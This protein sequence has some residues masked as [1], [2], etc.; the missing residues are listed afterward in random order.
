MKEKLY[1]L[2]PNVLIFF[3]ILSL[4]YSGLTFEK[5]IRLE[6][7]IFSTFLKNLTEIDFFFAFFEALK[8]IFQEIIIPLLPFLLLTMLGFSLAFL[9]RDIEF[10]VFMLFQA[11]FFAVLLF[12]N[13]SLITIFIYLGIIAASLSLKNFEK[14]EINFSSGSSLIQSCMKWL[15][16]FLSIGFFLSLQLN[17]QNYYKTIH[18]A[19]MDFIKM[20]VPDINSFIRAQTSQASQFINETTEGI[21]NALSDAYS[22]L[23]VQQREACGIMYTALV[24]AIDEYKTEAN[25]KV[26]Q[27]IEDADKK[28]E[29]YVEQI[30]PFDQIVKITPLILS[31]LL[32]T[33]LEI[34]KPLLALLFGILFSLAGKIKSK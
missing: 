6:S 20:F 30:V 7:E 23:D 9:T 2:I 14:R 33:L 22:K 3:G 29:E 8:A 32:F 5:A 28:V 10:P 18:Q 16:V 11:I 21:K 17:L 31:I 19:N 15:A 12:L 1:A 34:L 13:L 4:F 27:E 24:S 25:K 26:Y